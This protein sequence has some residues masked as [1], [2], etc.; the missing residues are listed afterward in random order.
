MKRLL[1][2]ILCITLISSMMILAGCSKSEPA[3]PD[4]TLTED[5]IAE[6]TA[7]AKAEYLKIIKDNKKAIKD[8]TWQSEASASSTFEQNLKP[9]NVTDINGDE[10]PELLFFMKDGKDAKAHMYIYTYGKDGV[11]EMDYSF[12]DGRLEDDAIG[13]GDYYVVFMD[14]EGRLVIYKSHGDDKFVTNIGSYVFSGTSMNNEYTLVKTD[15]IIMGENGLFKGFDTT[16]EKDGKLMDSS[17]GERLM[18]DSINGFKSVVMYSGYDGTDIFKKF[19]SDMVG[20]MSYEDA[21]KSLK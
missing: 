12:M 20:M 11:A 7:E 14:E 1:S 3:A 9:I 16:Y 4:D 17:K 15:S 8:Y 5:Q 13:S 19:N 2:Y 21:V 6:F 18:N 10:I